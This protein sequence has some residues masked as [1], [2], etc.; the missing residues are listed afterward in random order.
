MPPWLLGCRSPYCQL[1]GHSHAALVRRCQS[2][3]DTYLEL[4]MVQGPL[5]AS[6]PAEDAPVQLW[7]WVLRLQGHGGEAEVED[8]WAIDSVLQVPQEAL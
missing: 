3:Q 8:C 1:L 5:G 2:G 6:T 4:Q 7:C